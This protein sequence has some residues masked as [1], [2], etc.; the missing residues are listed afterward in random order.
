M[1]REHVRTCVACGR[2][3]RKAGL[4]RI[5]RAPDGTVS[6]DATG[7]RPGRGAYVCRTRACLDA[8]RRAHAIDRGLRTRVSEADWERLE[9][10]F[11]MLCVEHSDVQ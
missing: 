1:A 5:V 3:D 11:D 6:L 10:E 2:S 9:Q 8:A 4:V 7:K